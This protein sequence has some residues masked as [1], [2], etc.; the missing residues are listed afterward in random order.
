MLWVS[1]QK[2]K[3]LPFLIKLTRIYV[4]VVGI[5]MVILWLI[6]A[7]TTPRVNYSQVRINFFFYAKKKKLTFYTGQ[8]YSDA[9]VRDF[10]HGK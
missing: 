5:L 2:E 3:K 9:R 7:E 10:E 4:K 1:Y 8:D 6:S